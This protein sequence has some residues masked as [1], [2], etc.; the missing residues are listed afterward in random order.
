MYQK[1]EEVKS[2][3]AIKNPLENLKPM[4]RSHMDNGS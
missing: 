1:E 4:G 3:K 2:T